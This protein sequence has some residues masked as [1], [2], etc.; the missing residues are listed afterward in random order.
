VHEQLKRAPT[1]RSPSPRGRPEPDTVS[2]GNETDA[3]VQCHGHVL[4]PQPD[5]HW[6][7]TTHSRDGPRR[8]S[9]RPL[10]LDL[11]QRPP[12]AR[13]QP[14]SA[15]SEGPWRRCPLWSRAGWIGAS[16]RRLSE[17]HSPPRSKPSRGG[18]GRPARQ[19]VERRS[20]LVAVPH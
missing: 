1:Q 11:P 13:P 7:L 12:A 18:T 17:V 8:A 6:R 5:S 10:N 2:D 4:D 20:F 3:F 16:K 15:R 9:M 19:L 14:R